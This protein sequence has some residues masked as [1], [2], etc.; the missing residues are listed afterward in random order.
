MILISIFI[1]TIISINFSYG[2]DYEKEFRQWMKKFNVV[3]HDIETFLERLHIFK[4][5]S[6]FINE[7]N[8]KAN[9]HGYTLKHNEFSN[10]S[11]S[12]FRSFYFG[13]S[14]SDNYLNKRLRNQNNRIQEHFTNGMY[15]QD[16]IPDSIDWVEKGGVSAVKNQGQCGSCWAFSTTGA[17]EGAAFISGHVLEN[18]SEQELVD[19]DPA[20]NGCNGGLMDHAFYWAE[21][22]GGLCSE[23][24]YVYEAKR[25]ICKKASCKSV[26]TVTDF[27]DVPSNDENALK[28]AVAQQPVSVAI[29]ADQRSFQFYSNGVFSA[30][31]GTSLD[32]GVLVV[33]YGELDSKKYWKVKNSW[34]STWGLNGYILLE[35]D[36]AA[37]EGQCGVA[38]VPSYPI[39]SVS[40]EEV[41]NDS[42]TSFS[43]IKEPIDS[44]KQIKFYLPDY[45][46]DKKVEKA[47]EKEKVYEFLSEY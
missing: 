41:K 43:E 31:C 35:R 7:H 37:S 6:D 16:E 27:H 15:L 3:Y 26:I 19:C 36:I 46:K 40:R 39:A 14:F 23:D 25:G 8:K 18:L 21:N 28:Y 33:G 9:E 2:F 44:S 38:M 10:L 29:E 17:I 32:H 24:D 4:S 11:W 12:E 13:Y 47:H 20:D 34:G 1:F 30:K 5:N 22:H 42:R 45:N